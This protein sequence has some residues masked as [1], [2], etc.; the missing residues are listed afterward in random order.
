MNRYFIQALS[1]LGL[2]LWIIGSQAQESI[3]QPELTNWQFIQRIPLPEA[4]AMNPDAQVLFADELLLVADHGLQTGT[5]GEVLVFAIN[6]NDRYQR[7]QTLAAS[8]FGES[9]G[10]ADGFG[11]SLAYSDGN[12]FIG[13]PGDIFS[14]DSI[15]ASGMLPDGV[16]YTYSRNATGF[17]AQQTIR[18]TGEMFNQAWGTKLEAH[19]S[20]LL[21]Q[22]NQFFSPV[23]DM[24]L[25]LHG[26]ASPSRVNQ[27]ELE[28]AGSQWESTRV[29]TNIS[30]PNTSEVYGQDFAINESGIFITKVRLRFVNTNR[31]FEFHRMKVEVYPLNAEA[32]ELLVQEIL[33]P[34]SVRFNVGALPRTNTIAA[35]HESF[36][37]AGLCGSSNAFINPLQTDH[38]RLAFLGYVL[39]DGVWSLATDDPMSFSS[40][41]TT[42]FGQLS[43]FSNQEMILLS[44][45]RLSG[46]ELVLETV[47][48]PILGQ[49]ISQ[50]Q[51]FVNATRIS[52]EDLRRFVVTDR[53]FVTINNKSGRLVLDVFNAVPGLDPAITQA[54]WFGPEFGGQGVTFE[55]LRG[56][57]LLMHWF[58]Y[59]QFGKQMWLRGVGRLNKQGVVNISLVRAMGPR[60]PIDQFDP[61]DRTVEQWGEVMLRFN[62]CRSGHL[63]YRSDEFGSGELPLLPLVNNDFECNTGVFE[64]IGQIAGAFFDPDRNGEG[65]IFM[66]VPP[67]IAMDDELPPRNRAVGLWLT[68]T[69]TGEQAWYYLGIYEECFGVFVGSFN[70]CILQATQ[71]PRSTTGP[72]FGERYDPDD[73]ISVPW[74]FIGPLIV[75]TLFTTQR[76]IRFSNPHGDGFLSPLEQV[77]RPIGF[78]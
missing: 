6:N 49:A 33:S 12:L 51:R 76:S 20:F 55:V 8:G 19:G 21:I 47:S 41:C 48:S 52:I 57:R 39:E 7:V 59:D 42:A 10:Q 13:A 28:A 62:D 44:T 16:V 43:Q 53:H 58:T 11:F 23:S 37:V 67:S 1:G 45:D 18:G 65:I 38:P 31:G 17:D 50:R 70:A 61:E 15:M 2:A 56:N 77:T 25:T 26:Y 36:F 34:T 27:F 30:G 4:V 63:S 29:I 68:Y 72:I 66:P 54:W 3:E 5:C 35:Q 14:F 32:D 78:D 24:Q 69:P 74:G 40:S 64:P 9:C 60:F 22:G 75:D 73:R 71:N 46:N